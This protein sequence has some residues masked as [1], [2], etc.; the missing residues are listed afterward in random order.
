MPRGRGTFSRFE[1]ALQSLP[2]DVMLKSENLSGLLDTTLARLTLGA[3]ALLHTHAWGDITG[4]PTTLAG[5]GITDAQPLDSDLTD[6]AALSTTSFGRSLLTQADASAA[7][8]TLGLAIGTNVQAYDAELA[9]IAGLTSAADRVPYFTGS[10][11]AALATFTSAARNLLDDSTASAMCTT[12][13]VGTAD[14]PQFANLNL[15]DGTGQVR[16]NLNAGTSQTPGILWKVGGAARW[17]FYTTDPETGSDAGSNLVFGRAISDGGTGIDNPITITRAAGGMIT[18]VRPTSFNAG[19][20]LYG[21]TLADGYNLAAGSS[22]GSKIG[23]S[24]SQKIGLYGVTPVIQPAAAGQ[25]AVTLGN[26]DGEIGGLTIS[27]A[28]SQAEVTALRDKTEEL[29]DDVRN[30]S[31]LLHAVRSAGVSIGAWKGAA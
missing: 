11:T 30:L 9:A 22:T 13:G 15:G 14:S 23:T 26:T 25:A 29:A 18:I 27:A 1:T 4:T 7:R 6:I 17:L 5:Y 21:A 19:A 24:T 16:I 2:A 28:Y 10:G 8:T 31:T 20:T 12:L 3:A